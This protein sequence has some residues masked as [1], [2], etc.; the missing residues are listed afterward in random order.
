MTVK[1]GTGSIIEY[2]GEGAHAI[3][4]TGKGTICNMGAEIGATTSIFPYDSRMS[5][6][7]KATSREE[8]AKLADQIQEHL[9]AD[10]E[11]EEH[12][13]KYYDQLS[14]SIDLSELEPYVNGP[15]SPD[16]AWK[17]SELAE[18]VRQNAYPEKISVALI[19]SCTNSSYE[20]IER[21]VSIA[22]QAK[23]HGIKSKCPLTITPGSEQIRATIERDGLLKVLQEIGGLVLANACG[24][25]IGQWKRRDTISV[26]K[27]R[28]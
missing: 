9:K 2:F 17:I 28:S 8:V 19:G 10:P 21:A 25:C 15:Y 18:G 27:T 5:D 12:P 3:S 16:K 26:K 13:D 20:D 1:G 22:R 24:P 7:L 14:I 6:Y 11:I 4:A 23:K